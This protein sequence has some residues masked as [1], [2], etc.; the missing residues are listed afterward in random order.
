[1]SIYIKLDKQIDS[2]NLI[3]RIQK[4]IAGASPESILLITILVPQSTNIDLIKKLE[5]KKTPDESGA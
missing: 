2:N 3:E 5:N 1:M 4:L